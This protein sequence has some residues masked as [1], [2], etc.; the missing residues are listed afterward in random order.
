M[1]R[2]TINLYLFHMTRALIDLYIY[3]WL[4]LQYVYIYII[5]CT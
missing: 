3:I 5:I 2:A 4:E 1:T